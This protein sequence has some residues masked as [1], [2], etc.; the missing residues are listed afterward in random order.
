ML[1]LGP[2]LLQ[3]SNWFVEFSSITQLVNLPVCSSW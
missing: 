2:A 1:I 3:P